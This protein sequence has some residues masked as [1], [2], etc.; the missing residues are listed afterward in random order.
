M[1][2]AVVFDYDQVLY[3]YVFIRQKPLFDL[4]ERLRAEGVVT[5][6]LT[7]RLKPLALITKVLGSVSDF[8][9]V[10]YC[11]DI[12]HRKPDPQPFNIMLDQLQLKPEQC[13]YVDNREENLR[14]ARELGMQT[15]L[16]KN[17][18]QTVVEIKKLLKL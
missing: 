2:K 15:V 1:I 7:N 4:A 8:S 16:A 13:L 10:I 14:T 18:N 12:G 9:P 6:V 17:T 11:T 5:A 3:R